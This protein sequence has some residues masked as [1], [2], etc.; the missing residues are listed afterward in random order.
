MQRPAEETSRIAS[1]ASKVSIAVMCS[2]VLG[3]IR[4]QAFAIMFG[5]GFAFDSFVVAFRI[6]NLLRDLFG[7]GALSAAFVTVFADYDETRGPGAT[8][9]LAGNVLVFITILL[10]II[11]LLGIIFADKIVLALVDAD[12]E[13]IPDKVALTHL[14]TMIMFPFLIFISLSSVVMGILNTKGRFFVP[15]LASSFFN[16]GSIIG[17]VSLAFLLGEPNR[18]SIVGMAI[19]TL[20]GGLLQFGGQ[21]PSLVRSG[22]RFKPNLDLK[23]PGLRRILKLMAPAVFGLA[24]LQ[25]NVFINTYFASSLQEGSIS[26]LNYAFR[27]FQ[28]PVGVFGVAISVAA[29]PLLSRQAATSDFSSLRETFTSSLTMAFSL[30]IP[31]T[32]GLILLADP[33]IRLIF[34]HGNFSAVDTFKTAEALRF[35]ALGLFAYASVKVMVPVFYALDDTRYP[36]AGSFLAVGA[37]ILII[38]LSITPLQHKAMALSISGAMTANFFFLGA[39]LYR[40]LKGYSLSYI[41]TGLVKVFSAALLMGLYLFW[42]GSFIHNWMQRGFFNEL[43]GVLILVLSG[44]AVYGITLYLLKLQE[45]KVLVDK[46]LG[47]VNTNI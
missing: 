5:A 12:F 35:Y 31:A 8:W 30:T 38:L 43:S 22:F 2:R 24:A 23:D 40:K 33:I 6:P 32:V 11:T 41:G 14:L 9:K 16:L 1:S 25:I 39:I 3:L 19:G 34:E 36:V 15:A 42:S 13:K 27:F 29:L 17:G 4:E 44:A 26:W 20:I 47:R 37:N 7:E 46:L 18:P 10:S 28:F 21:L 45:L